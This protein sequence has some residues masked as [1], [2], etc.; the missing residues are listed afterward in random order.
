MNAPTN[1]QAAGFACLVVLV[2]AII[3]TI[4]GY[5]HKPQPEPPPT[6][7]TS[8]APPPQVSKPEPTP[9]PQPNPPAEATTATLSEA[10]RRKIWDDCCRS[11]DQARVE[12]DRRIPLTKVVA[13]AE[14]W[15]RLQDKA[16]RDV[17][18]RWSITDR[19]LTLIKVE[20][21]TNGWPLPPLPGH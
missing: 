12:A 1:R 16:D 11:Q 4:L 8:P 21:A 5:S 3:F 18:R 6:I 9:I 19:Q 13:N 2:L 10:T 7:S 17:A 15:R 14:L 20:G